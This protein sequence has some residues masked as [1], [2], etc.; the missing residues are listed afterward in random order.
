MFNSSLQAKVLVG[1]GC[2]VE[3]T[4]GYFHLDGCHWC[5]IKVGDGGSGDDY[6]EDDDDDNDDNDDDDDDADNNGD[7]CND[8][9]A[10]SD[11]GHGE[12]GTV[13]WFYN[14]INQFSRYIKI[15][16]WH[17]GLGNDLFYLLKSPEP[18]SQVWILILSTLFNLI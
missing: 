13:V 18:R 10:D 7:D 11:V 8:Y 1:T 17:H 12:G 2:R 3:L 6:D 5:D 4:K 15:H 14:S 16:T 9:D